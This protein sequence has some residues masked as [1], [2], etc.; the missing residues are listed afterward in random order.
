MWIERV[1]SGM[2]KLLTAL[3]D[4]HAKCGNMEEACSVFEEIFGR[5]FSLILH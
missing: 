4:K 1:S 2:N 3:V 5:M